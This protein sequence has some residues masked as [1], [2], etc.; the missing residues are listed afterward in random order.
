M[1]LGVHN[2]LF[3]GD[4]FVLGLW[5]K[6]AVTCIDGDPYLGAQRG[7]AGRRGGGGRLGWVGGLGGLSA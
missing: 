7:L 1:L 6:T 2:E 5:L 3:G 4:A